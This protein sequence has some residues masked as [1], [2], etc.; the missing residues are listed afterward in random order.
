MVR[1]ER[2]MRAGLDLVSARVI[3]IL[4]IID[5]EHVKT[6]YPNPSRDACQPTAIDHDS[7]FMLCTGSRGIISG[8]ASADLE[9]KANVGDYMAFSGTSI[10]DNSDDAVIIYGIDYNSGDKVFNKFSPTLVTRSNAVM[11]DPDSATGIPPVQTCVTFSSL[12]SR[13]KESGTE[14]FDLNFAL[15]TLAPNGEVQELFGYFYWVPTITVVGR[16]R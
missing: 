12:E 16:H 2:T 3:D 15:Y 13:V 6:T 10:Y 5:T 8:Q 9:F 1:R 11:P 4:V 14:S 7:H